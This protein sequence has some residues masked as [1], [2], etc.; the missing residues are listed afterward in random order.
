MNVCADRPPI[1]LFFVMFTGMLAVALCLAALTPSHDSSSAG[2]STLS[3][4]QSKLADV[5]APSPRSE[6]VSRPDPGVAR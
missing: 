1:L 6:P 2:A 5:N 4:Q 3:E